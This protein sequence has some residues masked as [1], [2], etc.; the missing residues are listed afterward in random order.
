[1]S[2]HPMYVSIDTCVSPPISYICPRMPLLAFFIIPGRTVSPINTD[3]TSGV[4]VTSPRSSLSVLCII[5]VH[6]DN[7][8]WFKY[9]LMENSAISDG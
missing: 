4:P 1:M 5:C 9:F 6:P 3:A 8:N 2:S 7:L